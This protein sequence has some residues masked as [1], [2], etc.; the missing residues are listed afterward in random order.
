MRLDVQGN[1]HPG[2]LTE[3]KPLAEVRDPVLKAPSARFGWLRHYTRPAG[4]FQMLYAA[5]FGWLASVE[6]ITDRFY[7]ASFFFKGGYKP[8][9]F[10]YHWLITT[11]LCALLSFSGFI[12]AYGL[13]RLRPWVRRWELAYLAFLAVGLA[14]E[15]VWIQSDGPGTPNLF[16]RTRPPDFTAP[17]LFTLAFSLPF[18][19]FLFGVAGG[20]S[21]AA[22]LRT[23]GKD[24]PLSASDG[25]RDRARRLRA[26]ERNLAVDAHRATSVGYSSEYPASPRERNSSRSKPRTAT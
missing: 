11:T 13:L 15:M 5:F 6:F 2:T 9:S 14:A 23:P 24:E 10:N 25:V 22:Q 19:P 20:E 3:P 21:D 18:V 26:R 16:A 12:G 17:I 7:T 4:V 1:N 8:E